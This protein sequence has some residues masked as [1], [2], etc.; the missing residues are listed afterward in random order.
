M[1]AA[2]A[3]QIELQWMRLKLKEYCHGT[4]GKLKGSKA[5]K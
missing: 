2:Q 4:Q 5:E 1:D 3:A